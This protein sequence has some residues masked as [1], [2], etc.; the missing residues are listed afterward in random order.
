MAAAAVVSEKLFPP[1]A[2]AADP[3]VPANPDPLTKP[4]EVR[5][6]FMLVG[7]NGDVPKVLPLTVEKSQVK[8]L[9]VLPKFWVL[10]VAAVPITTLF[11]VVAPLP[12]RTSPAERVTVPAPEPSAPVVAAL[13]TPPETLTAPV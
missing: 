13:R 6:A 3:E 2:V 8:R 12:P 1:Q 10:L 4:L 11:V 7:A 9:V 5:F